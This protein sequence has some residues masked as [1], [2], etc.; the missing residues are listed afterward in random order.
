MERFTAFSFTHAMRARALRQP[1]VT[2]YYFAAFTRQHRRR[3]LRQPRYAPMHLDRQ[4]MP[5]HDI[6]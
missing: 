6:A 4:A 5:R 2:L 1:A 3:P